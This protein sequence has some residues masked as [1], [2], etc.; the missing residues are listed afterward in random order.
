[1][2]PVIAC[3]A[4]PAYRALS[5]LR[6][7]IAGS[8]LHYA[9]S[10]SSSYGP[11]V[12]FRLLSTPPRG[13]AVTFGYGVVAHSDADFHRVDLATSR[14]HD[15][16]LLGNDEILAICIVSRS[17]TLHPAE[18]SSMKLGLFLMPA[19]LPG[20]PLAEALDWNLR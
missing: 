8:P 19:T 4:I 20:R 2:R 14:S 13:D 5:G 6:H 15:S 11:T 10:S 9:E 12:R 18:G 7:G 1:M 16:R 17:N 3:S